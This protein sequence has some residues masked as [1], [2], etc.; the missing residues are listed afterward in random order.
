M[1]MQLCPSFSKTLGILALDHIRFRRTVSIL[2]STG[3][4]LQVSLS[5]LLEERKYIGQETMRRNHGSLELLSGTTRSNT[6]RDEL[7]YW[8]RVRRARG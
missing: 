6:P 5:F 7:T 8:L 1:L 2:T 4:R 3:A